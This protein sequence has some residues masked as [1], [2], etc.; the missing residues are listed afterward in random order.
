MNI[1]SLID[2]SWPGEANSAEVFDERG[3]D[4]LAVRKAGLLK[5]LKT[6]KG[7]EGE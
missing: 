2:C 4:G 1:G 7:M 5:G 3:D 6:E